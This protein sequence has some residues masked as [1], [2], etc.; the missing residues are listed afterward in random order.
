MASSTPKLGLYKPGP[1]E[2]IDVT[3][4]LNQNLDK[5]DTF[6]SKTDLGWTF[7]ASGGPENNSFTID[8]T[9]GGKW[10]AGTFSMVRVK[11]SGRVATAGS[12]ILLRVNNDSTADLHRRARIGFKFTDGLVSL[13]ASGL[14]TSWHAGSWSSDD[15][16]LCEFTIFGTKVSAQLSFVGNTIRTEA[17][18]TSTNNIYN[19]IGGDLSVARLLDNL[20]V[21]NGSFRDTLWVAEGF[22]EAIP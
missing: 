6:A 12:I 15:F 1:A 18:D 5:I 2:I 14:S 17:S 16:N 19:I 21:D 13:S 22:L 9:D 4:D 8:I 10:P 3:Q 7:I 20:R 11:M